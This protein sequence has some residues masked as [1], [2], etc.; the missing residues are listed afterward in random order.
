MNKKQYEIIIG[1]L[2]GDAWI[3]GKSLRIKQSEAHKD[4]VFWL[5]SHLKNL[6]NNPPKQRSDYKQWYFQ[7][8]FLKEI[9]DYKKLFYKNGRKIVPEN[10]KS[11]LVSPLSLAVWYMD[12]GSLDFRPKDHYNFSLCTNTFTIE[13]NK[14]LVNVLKENFGV[15][16]SIQT[17][18]C[19]GKRYPEIYI[20][21]KGRDKFFNLISPYILNCFSN[22]IPSIL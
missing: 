15:E 14:L 13:E 16:C 9:F 3:D 1:T 18:H 8:K 5:Y 10:I 4:Y 21:S 2:L 20:G 12:D 22:R 19:R 17:P 11:L 6:C 7:T